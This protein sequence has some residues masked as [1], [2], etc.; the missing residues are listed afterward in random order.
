L[1]HIWYRQKRGDIGS[2]RRVEFFLGV[3]GH[4]FVRLVP[5]LAPRSRG[6]PGG[7]QLPQN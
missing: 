1:K 7:P 6:R 2:L 3:Q 5:G 4:S